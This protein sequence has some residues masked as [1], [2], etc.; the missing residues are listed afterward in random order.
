M[1]NN[2]NNETFTDFNITNADNTTTGKPI[3][4]F[5]LACRCNFEDTCINDT[6]F[7]YTINKVLRICLH[8]TDSYRFVSIKELHIGHAGQALRNNYA[9]IVNETCT[10]AK[11]VLTVLVL[12]HNISGNASDDLIIQGIA[13]LQQCNAS[14]SLVPDPVQ[15]IRFEVTTS[16]QQTLLK[17]SHLNQLP[18]EKET[19]RNLLLT[20]LFLIPLSFLLVWCCILPFCLLCDFMGMEDDK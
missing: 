1:L 16:V 5:H 6:T 18:A 10:N 9:K 4:R 8:A 17:E 13:R 3:S 19:T 2:P 12:P 14:D 15:E 20:V 11:C 7:E